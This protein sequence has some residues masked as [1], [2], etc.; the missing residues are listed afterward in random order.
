M[1]CQ[2]EEILG[3]G[4]AFLCTIRLVVMSQGRTYVF[5]PEG[6]RQIRHLQQQGSGG[7]KLFSLLFLVEHPRLSLIISF[8]LV[9]FLS[10]LLPFSLTSPIVDQ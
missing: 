5:G 8:A 6:R 4:I 2:K 10:L 3:L 9:G 7:M 1:Y